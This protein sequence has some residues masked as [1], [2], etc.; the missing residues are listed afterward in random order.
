M[1]KISPF[2]YPT[3]VPVWLKTALCTLIDA[4][5]AQTLIL[6][7]GLNARPVWIRLF[8]DKTRVSPPVSLVSITVLRNFVL[9]VLLLGSKKRN[10]IASISPALSVIKA[11]S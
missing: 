6:K 2:L 5:N 1:R 4:L 11:T 8:F 10:K 9:N 7:T 3:K